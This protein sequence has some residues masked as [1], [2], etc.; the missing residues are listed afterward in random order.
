MVRTFP[1]LF[2]FAASAG[3]SA[4]TASAAPAAAAPASTSRAPLREGDS[5]ARLQRIYT[6]AA[7]G[8]RRSAL[9][10]AQRLV[11]DYPHFQLAQWVYAELLAASVRPEQGA[12]ARPQ[13]HAAT[14]DLDSEA[15]L[16]LKALRERPPPGTIPAQFLHLPS[17]TRHAIAVD[18][19]RARLY[20]L[21]NTGQGLRVVADYYTS[22]GKLGVEKHVE[23]DM[24]TPLGVYF[25]NGS[26]DAKQ[27]LDFYG[28]GALTLNYPN[29][30]DQRRGK[31]GSGIWLHGTPP[32]Q[33]V[34][35]PQATDGCIVLANADLTRLLRT[36][37]IRS[38][39]VVIARQLEWVAPQSLQAD[40]QSFAQHLQAWQ[41][42]KSQGDM[43]KLMAF[44]A[45][46]FANYGSNLSQWRSTLQSEVRQLKGRKLQLKE[47][48]YMRWQGSPSEDAM[49][50][51]FGEVAQG[52]RSGPIKRQYWLRQEGQW[53][54]FFEGVIG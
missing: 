45:A 7:Q 1:F 11:Q 29:P 47:L 8:E 3:L 6:L 15:R 34:R 17:S 33:F 40:S 30:Y 51:T 24:R 20:L 50:V 22:V 44:Y 4:S 48:S 37:Q 36:V 27:L 43:D 10:Q 16:R 38:T 49:V 26:I 42:A 25:I 12:S 35:A 41:Q 32:D 46:D 23:G 2:L 13:G 53:K 31:T 52:T 28:N 9:A 14:A 18:A 5:E 19:S 54:I 21:E 39:P